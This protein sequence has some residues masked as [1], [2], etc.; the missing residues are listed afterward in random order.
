MAPRRRVRW[1]EVLAAISATLAAA[2][3]GA[4]PRTGAGRSRGRALP[5]PDPD[6][7]GWRR[8]VLERLASRGYP[9]E[10]LTS[11]G[12]GGPK[13][14]GCAPE[15]MAMPKAEKYDWLGQ[16]WEFPSEPKASPHELIPRV[17]HFVISDRGARVFDWT[18]LLAVRAAR[19]AVQP[20]EILLHVFEGVRPPGPFFREAETMGRVVPFGREEVP[21]HICREGDPRG[22]V[23]LSK[24]AHVADFRRLQ[25]LH[26]QG[27]I[28]MDLDHIAIAPFDRLLNYT[29]VWGRQARNENGMQVMIGCMLSA[30]GNPLVADLLREMREAYD[31]QWVE[32]SINM[33][34]RHLAARAQFAEGDEFAPLIMPY[35]SLLSFS[36]KRGDLC[37]DYWYHNGTEK[38][39]LTEGEGFDWSRAF[40]FHLFHS[41]SG[42]F[43][44]RGFDEDEPQRYLS[45]ENNFAQGVR[46]GVSDLPGFIERLRQLMREAGASREEIK[47]QIDENARRYPLPEPVDPPSSRDPAEL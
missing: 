8:P 22:C 25:V 42:A 9:P 11:C 29:S 27:G 26:E 17:V 30:P 23:A 35:G 39:S 44:A 43:L 40:S 47:R 19:D 2:E 12:N 14:I 10:E 20:Q 31:G 45:R 6:D 38:T 3:A 4:N 24:A 33:L 34:N 16:R 7:V 37:C 21:L 46:R 1:A 15:W 36:W 18:H 5:P 32:H 28:Y 13:G 41:Q